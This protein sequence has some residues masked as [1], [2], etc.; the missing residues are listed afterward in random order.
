ME[1][2]TAMW[3]SNPYDK[4]SDTWKIQTEEPK[5]IRKLRK[6]RDTSVVAWSINSNLLIFSITYIS[7]FKAMK[8]LKRLTGRDVYYNAEEGVVLTKT[9]PILTSKKEA[10][11]ERNR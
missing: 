10:E 3:K 7:R 4:Q 9:A 2:Q 5:V 1:V 11:S 6:R 8:G